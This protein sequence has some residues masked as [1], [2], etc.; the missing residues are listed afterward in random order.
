MAWKILIT[1]LLV[2]LTVGTVIQK[3]FTDTQVRTIAE[4]KSWQVREGSLALK[5]KIVYAVDNTFILD[6]GT[7]Q[8]ELST[9]P[10]WHKRIHLYT[11]DEVMVTG[12]IMRNPSYTSNPDFVFSVFKIFKGREVIQVR[13]GPGKP[14]WKSRGIPTDSPSQGP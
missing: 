5:G 8:V 13:R 2:A 12:E 14:P 6:D 9:C 10:L 11:G 4:A 3:T 7:G 1:V